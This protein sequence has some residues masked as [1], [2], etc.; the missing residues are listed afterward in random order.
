MPGVIT[1]KK[2]PIMVSWN[3]WKKG[4]RISAVLNNR[5]NRAVDMSWLQNNNIAART[6]RGRFFQVNKMVM[7]SIDILLLLKRYHIARDARQILR[8][9]NKFFLRFRRP[10]DSDFSGFL[11]RS[12]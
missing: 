9:K 1:L 3:V 11:H 4:K 12:G 10:M 2:L 8:N 6:I 5:F 7:F